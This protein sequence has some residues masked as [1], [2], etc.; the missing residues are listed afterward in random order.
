M[1]KLSHIKNFNIPF[2]SIDF[3]G[4]A[5]V[6]TM[7]Q[8][9]QELA[10]EHAKILDLGMEKLLE[11]NLIWVLV[12]QKVKFKNFPLWQDEIIVKTWA[13]GTDRLFW[14]RDF[15]IYDKNNVE[16]AR[17]SSSWIIINMETRR[18]FRADD[19]LKIE[20]KDPEFA[21]DD[22]LG[23]LSSVTNE[24]KEYEKKITF[25]DLDLNDHVN[26]VKYV[27]W[28]LDSYELD[29]L[30]QYSIDTIELNYIAEAKYGEII[31]TSSDKIDDT[32]LHSVRND[33]NKELFR[34]KINW[35]NK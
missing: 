15:M 23:K 9:F 26:N 6:Q 8:Y 2:Y 18:P 5:T 10:W 22:K 31:Y 16:L 19:S 25:S 34:A 7:L 30:K 28:I 35:K 12:R 4:K 21:F 32:H 11:Q 20:I 13:T 29:Y 1:K 17:A 14:N 24:K 33:N 27:E 3:N